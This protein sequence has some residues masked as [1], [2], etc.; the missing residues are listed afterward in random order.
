MVS[1]FNFLDSFVIIV[2]ADVALGVEGVILAVVYV[3]LVV[4]V[5]VV[6]VPQAVNDLDHS[7]FTSRLE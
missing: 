4:S 6:V 5:V 2:I 1:S 7:A 3:V